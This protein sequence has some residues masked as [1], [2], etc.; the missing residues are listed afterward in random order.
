MGQT[1]DVEALT[2]V[3]EVVLANVVE[4]GSLANNCCSWLGACFVPLLL[5]VA[6]TGEVL[7]VV[8]GEDVAGYE[9]GGAVGVCCCGGGAY[10]MHDEASGEASSELPMLPEPDVA[11]EAVP[12]AWAELEALLLVW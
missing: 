4:A 11:V 10:W 6:V 5:L 7:V 12:A 2:L 1:G 8:D 9:G 3:E